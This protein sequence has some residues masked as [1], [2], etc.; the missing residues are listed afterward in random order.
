MD[1]GCWR[2]VLYQRCVSTCNQYQRSKLIEPRA[3]QFIGSCVR[4]HLMPKIFVSCAC[5]T[6]A[7]PAQFITEWSKRN[8]P[9][10]A[11]T[12]DCSR[13]EASALTTSILALPTLPN[14]AFA[15]FLLL[16]S[17]SSSHAFSLLT[18]GVFLDSISIVVRAGIWFRYLVGSP[19]TLQLGQGQL[20][21][22]IP[23]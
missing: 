1:L 13:R 8:L 11:L 23:T 7:V 14:C 21:R 16:L 22:R 9:N 4:T 15:V 2:V 19:K 18:P 10:S 6:E 17:S 3:L 12:V 20:D 5:V